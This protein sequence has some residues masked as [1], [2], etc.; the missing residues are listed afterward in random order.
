MTNARSTSAAAERRVCIVTLGCPK[1]EVDSDRMRAALQTSGFRFVEEPDDAEIVIL[2]TC[3][4]IEAAVEESISE[5][6][7]L[8][9]WRDALP[10]RRLVVAGCMV[11]RY[12]DDLGDAL[13][14]A[15]ALVPVC[16]EGSIG[17]IVTNLTGGRA[18]SPDSERPPQPVNRSTDTG[19]TAYLMI[20]DGC[21]RE[22]AF[23]TIPQ[24]RG[25]YVSRTLTD[26]I[27][28]ARH[29]VEAGAREL[30]LIG[31]DISSWGRDLP[32]PDSLPDVIR[33]VAAVPGVDW[34]R[35]MYV[36]PDGVDDELLSVI[37]ETPNV[38]NYLDI[39]LQHVAVPVLRAMRRRGSAEEFRMLA[40][41]IRHRVPDVVLRTTFIAGFPG[42]SA[43]D[44]SELVS[45][46]EDVG[47]DY[48]GVFPYS[49]EEGTPA[50]E[51]SGQIDSPTRLLRAQA[52]RDVADL[53]SISRLE[54]L[55]GSSLEILS[56]G[57]DEEGVPVGRWRGQAPEIDGVV[58]LDREVEAGTI[59]FARI[60]DTL[61]YDLEGE[62]Q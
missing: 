4:F 20:S 49:P 2:N 17:E 30:V 18:L 25:D 38:C 54:R 45:F 14:E 7:E 32:T 47:F 48:V 3:G 40:Q 36:Q 37:A 58:L 21:H 5:A 53:V 13:S 56:E 26:I 6:L 34:L 31:Q 28:E 51:L 24:I 22:C 29:L 33:G 44:I 57:M 12:G 11:S 10:G 9:E 61:G 23:C 41:R 15:D 52:L 16:D 60:T 55:I 46:I 8:A 39:P 62:V 1:N 42:E 50:F 59:V 35:L 27:E 19:P 43:D